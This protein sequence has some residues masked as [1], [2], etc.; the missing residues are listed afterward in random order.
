MNKQLFTKT[1]VFCLIALMTGCAAPKP[2]SFEIGDKQ[3]LLNG[4]P[5][6]IKAA[7]MHYTRIPQPYW[8]HRIKMSKSLGMNTICLYVFWNIHEQE[9]GVFDFEGQN[10]VAEFCRLAQ[11]EGMYVIVRP[12]PYVCAEWEMGGLPW[13]LLQK[14]G[15]ALRSQDPYYMERVGIFMNEV[16]KHLADLQ[17]NRGGNIIMVQVENE[18]GSYGTDK[19]YVED[20]RDIVRAAGFTDVPLFQCDWNTNFKNNALDDL[21]WTINFGTGANIDNQF[22][23]LQALRPNTPLMCSEFWSGWFDRWGSPHETRSAQ[24]LVKGMREMLEKDIS[25]SLYMTHGGSTFGHWTG[26]NSPPYA[27]WCSSYDYDAPISESGQATEKFYAVRELLAQYSDKA[28]PKVPKALPMIEIPAFELTQVAPLFQNLP[29]AI[30][31]DQVRSMEFFDQG[32]GSILYRTTLPAG[33]I[34]RKLIVEDVHDWAIVFVDGK[35]LG[36][37]DRRKAEKVLALPPTDQDAVLDILV[38]NMGRVNYSKT[39]HDYKGI[40]QRVSVREGK[41]RQ[42]LRGF[43]IYPIRV[44]D[45]LNPDIQFGER[46]EQCRQPA[47]HQGFFDLNKTGDVYLDMQS[48][49]K[50]LVWVNGYA[51][52]RFW[53]IGPQQTLFVPGCWLH[54]GRNEIIILDMQGP[55]QAL[56]SGITTPILDRLLSDQEI[57]DR[58]KNVDPDQSGYF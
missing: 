55:K 25:F 31:S 45:A 8:E 18:F 44:E 26:A 28:L 46:S 23:E 4:E 5:F 51:I 33:K 35:A 29:P 41:S 27:S 24:D 42:E 16:G 40:T 2:S 15:I 34:G 22:R 11:K 49:S 10:N 7:E 43:E 32:Y 12:G 30:L 21:L 36:T 53:E 9:I 13:W 48:W 58:N 37:L 39:I 17:I 57:M 52:G 6:V 50:G 1:L 19:P 38:E 14:E 3:F 56:V 47:Y 20:I 54:Q